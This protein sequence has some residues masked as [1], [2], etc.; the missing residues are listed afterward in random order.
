MQLII[1]A[2]ILVAAFLKSAVTR[3]L[4]FDEDIELFAPEY[5][6]IEVAQTINKNKFLS[7]YTRLTK[8]EVEGLLNFLLKPIKIIP[9]EDYNF[10]I[11]NNNIYSLKR[12]P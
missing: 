12:N 10:F 6:A 9:E 4:L 5:F 2:N 3:E 8:E 11:E 1:D 7:K